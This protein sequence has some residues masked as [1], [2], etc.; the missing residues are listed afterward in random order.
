MAMEIAIERFA[1]INFIVIGLS[2]A[3]QPVGW[4]NFFQMLHNKGKAGAFVNGF[5][6]LGTGALIVAF[7][8]VWT[9]PSLVLTAIGYSYVLKS[10]V[11]FVRPEL[12]LK[13][14]ERAIDPDRAKKFAPVGVMMSILGVVIGYNSF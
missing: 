6:T 3:F 11:I 2:H 9:W 13:S 12:G 5:L 10:V 8:N 4:A 14:M 7:H 1:A